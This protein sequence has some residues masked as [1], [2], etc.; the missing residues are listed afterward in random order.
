MRSWGKKVEQ[1]TFPPTS[2]FP[3]FLSSRIT[4]RK[5]HLVRFLFYASINSLHQLSLL[6]GFSNDF[7]PSCWILRQLLQQRENSNWRIDRRNCFLQ[8]PV[9]KGL[10]SIQELSESVC[11]WEQERREV[12]GDA[13]HCARTCK[14]FPYV[15]GYAELKVTYWKY[16]CGSVP[17][18]P[19]PFACIILSAIRCMIQALYVVIVCT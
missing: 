19:P 11:N 15:S 1:S 3:L 12:L 6:Q 18:T 8:L 17:L 4:T 16:I 14:K 13:L 9:S 7:Q 5:L 2:H 10:R